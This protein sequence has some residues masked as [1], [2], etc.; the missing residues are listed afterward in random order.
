MTQISFGVR[1]KFN[2]FRKLENSSHLL[3]ICRQTT[4]SSA[5]KEQL[6]NAATSRRKSVIK[7][8]ELPP[9]PQESSHDQTGDQVQIM[10]SSTRSSTSMLK[11]RALPPVPQESPSEETTNRMQTTPSLSTAS[12]LLSSTSIII[13][14][15]LPL[16]SSLGQSTEQPYSSAPGSTGTLTR[17]FVLPPFLGADWSSMTYCSM[18][19]STRCTGV[20]LN[21]NSSNVC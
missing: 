7:N 17:V 13:D 18:L 4:E 12:I 11:N 19:L 16:N 15:T 8:R 10:P 21:Q 5:L 20:H 1:T 2:H 3:C 9:I 14:G 6:P